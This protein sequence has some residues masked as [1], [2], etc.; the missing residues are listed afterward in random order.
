L[1]KLDQ[2]KENEMTR[3][4]CGRKFAINPVDSM[5][6]LRTFFRRLTPGG[7]RKLQVL[8]RL[9]EATQRR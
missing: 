4:Y 2:E 3:S 9:A 7:R 6:K 1:A 8:A 5:N